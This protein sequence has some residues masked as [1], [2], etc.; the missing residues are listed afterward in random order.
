VADYGVADAETVKPRNARD[1]VDI[2]ARCVRDRK[3]A[4][5]HGAG[6][7][8]TSVAR[9]D[10]VIVDPE[11]LRGS[12]P[13]QWLRRDVAHGKD[14]HL[15]RVLSGTTVK[16]LNRSILPAHKPP[17]SLPNMGSFDGQTVIGAISTG[18]HGSGI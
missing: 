7:S 17:L 15:V 10:D 4:R 12:L 6:H 11:H 5:A 1:L 3:S 18:T 16:E 13:L 9:A 14:E 8:T 2:V